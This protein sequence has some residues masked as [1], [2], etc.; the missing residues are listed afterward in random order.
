MQNQDDERRRHAVATFTAESKSLLAQIEERRTIMT[1]ANVDLRYRAYSARLFLDHQGFV[2]HMLDAIGHSIDD[3]RALGD[4]AILQFMK[5]VPTLNVEA[6]IA[7]RLEI[8]SGALESNDILDVQSFYTAIPY[9]N[10]LVAE[11]DFTSLARQAKLDSKYGVSLH[12]NLN[13]LASSFE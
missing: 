11:R 8:Q 6:E 12:T 4:K 2:V 10:R 5:G 1:G 13:E 9:S 3:M 7:A